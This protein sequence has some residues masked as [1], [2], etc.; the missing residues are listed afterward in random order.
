MFTAESTLAA[1]FAPG[2]SR[3]SPRWSM[4]SEGSAN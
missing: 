4:P 3:R 2:R 1:L